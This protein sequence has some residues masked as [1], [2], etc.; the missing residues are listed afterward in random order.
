ML[1]YKESYGMIIHIKEKNKMR[2]TLTGY[3]SIQTIND[4][5]F[6]QFEQR[7]LLELSLIYIKHQQNKNNM[8]FDTKA[9]EG[10]ENNINLIG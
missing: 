5:V 9:S 8:Y 3:N 7:I 10:T 1:T 2:L 4:V 6:K